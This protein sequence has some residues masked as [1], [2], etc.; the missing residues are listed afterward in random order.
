MELTQLFLNVQETLRLNSEDISGQM[1][2]IYTDIR[3]PS[4]ASCTKISL[5]DFINRILPNLI[6][7]FKQHHDSNKGGTC[8]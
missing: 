4:E 1:T 2:L 7:S 8:G 5:L 6:L 3:Q